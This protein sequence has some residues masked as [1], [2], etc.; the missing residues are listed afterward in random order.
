[1]GACAGGVPARHTKC[2]AVLMMRLEKF[3]RQGYPVSFMPILGLVGVS[4]LTT[5]ILL[6]P[7]LLTMQMELDLPWYPSGWIRNLITGTHVLSGFLLVFLLGAVA[8]V[9]I[10]AGWL[11]GEKRLSG[12]FATGMITLLAVTAVLLLYSPL[13]V[14]S[15]QA[16]IMHLFLGIALP[17]GIGLH[18]RTR[19]RDR[20]RGR[21]PDERVN[22]R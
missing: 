15:H 7:L 9:H 8:I 14:L 11:R 19:I 2:R 3:R 22:S 17:I 18:A 4:L 13:E 21:R 1:M 20:S 12:T 5:G 16:A 6:I 10:R